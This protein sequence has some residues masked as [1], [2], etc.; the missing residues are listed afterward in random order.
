MD[1]ELKSADITEGL[2]KIIPLAN[3]EYVLEIPDA[4]QERQYVQ[5]NRFNYSA[6]QLFEIKKVTHSGYKI[7]PHHNKLN[8]YATREEPKYL[9]Q[10]EQSGTAE[11]TWRFELTDR[12]GVYNIRTE[13][14]DPRYIMVNDLN[15]V[16]V[17]GSHKGDMENFK[18]E[19]VNN[20]QIENGKYQLITKC[21]SKSVLEISNP[22]S[23]D[24]FA[25]INQNFNGS[26][27]QWLISNGKLQLAITDEEKKVCG[28]FLCVEGDENKTKIRQQEPQQDLR[29][30]WVFERTGEKDC[31]YIRSAYSGL[32]VDLAYSNTDN[33]TK[34]WQHFFNGTNAQKWK[35]SRA[36]K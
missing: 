27:Q 18:L 9:I 33:Y 19:L 10:S 2:Y 31:Y 22:S 12:E 17:T 13:E 35:F 1:N 5:I 4:S 24:A 16:I 34:V 23:S 30:N 3:P 7:M 20:V 6:N 25:T 36:D 32:Y 28:K 8:L 15:K 11:S 26:N 29:Q 21:N 14:F